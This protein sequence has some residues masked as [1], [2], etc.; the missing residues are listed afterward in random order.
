MD[1]QYATWLKS[2]ECAA[3]KS[4]GKTTIKPVKG[5][6]FSNMVKSLRSEKRKIKKRLKENDGDP[7][8]L[9]KSYKEVQ[10]KIRN[11]I[12]IERTEKTN[13]QLNKMTED[14]SRVIF[15]KE[16]KKIKRNCL[17]DCLTVK[18]EKGERQYAPEKVKETTA[19][20]YEKLYSIRPTRHH[21]H[22]NKVEIEMNQYINNLAFESEWYNSPPTASEIAEIIDNK[23]N[24]KASTDLTNEIIKG[25]KDQFTKLYM[26]RRL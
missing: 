4:I 11:Q 25:T 26:P 7:E 14:K 17:N 24:G 19:Q 12:L 8:Q 9:T 22:H 2:I 5:E 21:P 3:R 10:E 18:N 15:W 13:K 16:R 23:K 6:N 20:Y 1:K